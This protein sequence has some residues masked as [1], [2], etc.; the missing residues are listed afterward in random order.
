MVMIDGMFGVFFEVVG[1]MTCVFFLLWG[2]SILWTEFKS[3]N[4]N[5]KPPVGE[6]EDDDTY[7]TE[8]DLYEFKRSMW[9]YMEG[10]ETRLDIL[11]D[12]VNVAL[13]TKVSKKKTR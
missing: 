4:K 9:D 12:E 11:E 5:N 10:L 2:V 8:D 13:A 7:S 3:R 6:Y 1:F